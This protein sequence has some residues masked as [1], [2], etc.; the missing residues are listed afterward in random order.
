MRPVGH[1]SGRYLYD[2]LRLELWQR[3]HPDVPWLTPAAVEFLTEWICPTDVV[4]EWGSG[5]STV[6]FSRYAARVVSVEHD[7]TWFA[8]VA[9]QLEL[10]GRPVVEQIL[11]ADSPAREHYDDSAYVSAGDRLAD[12]SVD[13]A[14]VDGIFRDTCALAAAGKVRPGGLLIVDNANW[15]LPTVSRSPASRS[16]ATGAGSAGW[17]EFLQ[18][19]ESWRCYWTSSGVTDTAVYFAPSGGTEQAGASIE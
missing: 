12:R 16:L 4:L 18:V 3:Q 8:R 9:S 5:R 15:Y 2:R 7:S 10:D 13:I 1:L 19:V 11:A 14:L 17:V 6:W